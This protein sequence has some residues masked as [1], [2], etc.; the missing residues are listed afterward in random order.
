MK[1][2]V[3]CGSS[4]GKEPIFK[5]KAIVLANTL[6]TNEH[7]L[8]YGGSKSGLMGVIADT[9]L[10]NKKNVTGVITTNL[11]KHELAHNSLTNLFT[12][13]N[14]QQRKAMMYEL[15]D[16]FI[17]MPGGC[18][19]MEEF[20]E[21][22]SWGQLGYHQKP[23]GI[24]NIQNYYDKLLAFLDEMS[25]NEFMKKRFK[26]MLIVSDDINVILD[27]FSKYVVPEFKWSQQ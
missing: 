26:D 15:S 21:I 27:S 7:E 4:F 9:M 17:I 13:D 16:A 25:E 18:G 8:I 24:Y 14:I 11:A 1:I 10:V 12:V 2:A 23:I 19:T 22:Y 6:A 5:E 20:F 3:F